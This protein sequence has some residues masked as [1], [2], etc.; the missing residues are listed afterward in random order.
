[1][2]ILAL[3]LI[4]MG[5]HSPPPFATPLLWTGSSTLYWKTGWGAV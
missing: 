4:G 3:L 5:G 1:L 2:L